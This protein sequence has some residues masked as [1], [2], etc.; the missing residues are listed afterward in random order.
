MEDYVVNI[1]EPPVVDSIVINNGDAQR[2]AV[3][4]V[5]LTFDQVVE[6]DN[7][8]GKAFTFTHVGT[9][10]VVTNVADIDDT[11]GKTVVDFTFDSSGLSVTS[12]GSL[13][14]GDYEL[15]IDA[16]RVTR[17]WVLNLM[18]TTTGSIGRRLCHVGDRRTI[19]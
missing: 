8:D 14:N 18:A 10:E 4:S 16:S 19:S 1:G 5:Q 13:A 6:I 2:S 7:A 12:F 3:K 9:G 15:T 11:S 17:L